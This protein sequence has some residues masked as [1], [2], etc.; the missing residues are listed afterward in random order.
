[1]IGAFWLAVIPL[2]GIYWLAAVHLNGAF[3][4]AVI[5][6][7]AAFWL[8]VIPLNGA[9]WLAVIPLIDTPLRLASTLIRALWFSLSR[10]SPSGELFRTLV[11]SHGLFECTLTSPS[12]DCCTLID[13]L[14]GYRNMIGCFDDHC[15]SD[16]FCQSLHSNCL[17]WSLHTE[18]HFCSRHSD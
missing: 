2:K 8:A 10:S 13:C 18:Y 17:S 12:G 7:N 4:L 1:M 15:E 9:F 16:W 3:W 11:H 6:L 14:D 5:R